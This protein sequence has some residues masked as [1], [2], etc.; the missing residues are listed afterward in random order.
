MTKKRKLLIIPSVILMITFLLTKTF[1]LVG[2]IDANDITRIIEMSCFLLFSPLFY[3]L[4]KTQTVE[5]KGEL[6]KQIKDN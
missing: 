3:F 6:L 5:L 1:I 2:L 4:M